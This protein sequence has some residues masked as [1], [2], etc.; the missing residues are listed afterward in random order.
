MRCRC[1]RAQ[2]HPDFEF[3]V[4]DRVCINYKKLEGRVAYVGTVHFADGLWLGIVLQTQGAFAVVAA[5]AVVLHVGVS[6]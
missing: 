5:E 4:G 2:R 1:R 6:E 3:L